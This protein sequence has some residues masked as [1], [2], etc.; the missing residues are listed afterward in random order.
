MMGWKMKINK[1]KA[2]EL[3]NQGT[4][5]YVFPSKANTGSPWFP[6]VS[7]TKG[8]MDFD[9]FLNHF[10]YYNCNSELGLSCKFYCD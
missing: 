10:R 1:T 7:F 4:P 5:I 6:W 3:Y 8:D 9:T 2:R